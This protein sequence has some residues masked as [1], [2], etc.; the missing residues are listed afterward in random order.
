MFSSACLA[1]RKPLEANYNADTVS[2]KHDLEVNANEKGIEEGLGSEGVERSRGREE[3]DEE[4]AKRRKF[5]SEGAEKREKGAGHDHLAKR[6]KMT[7]KV[8][9]IF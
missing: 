9:P 3:S 1:R 4:C 2:P 8:F 6:D 7:T 5:I